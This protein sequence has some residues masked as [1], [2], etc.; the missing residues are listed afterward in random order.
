M[1]NDREWVILTPE[2]YLIW[3]ENRVTFDPKAATHFTPEKA[4]Q[5]HASMDGDA[6]Y[7]KDESAS[8]I[9]PAGAV[10]HRALGVAA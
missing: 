4:V 3:P 6:V 1:H 5:V 10:A 9:P 2:G 8:P 7:L